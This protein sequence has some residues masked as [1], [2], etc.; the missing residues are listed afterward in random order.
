MFTFLLFIIHLLLIINAQDVTT[1]FRASSDRLKDKIN[2]EIKKLDDLHHQTEGDIQDIVKNMNEFTQ[3]EHDLLKPINDIFSCFS[4][5]GEEQI[6]IAMQL[7]RDAQHT[8]SLTEQVMEALYGDTKAQELKEDRILLHDIVEI[9]AIDLLKYTLNDLN[10]NLL[11]LLDNEQ[12]PDYSR[13]KQ[14][15]QELKTNM[16]ILKQDFD[17]LREQRPTN[18][19]YPIKADDIL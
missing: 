15:I 17:S 19:I 16:E 7:D 1:T 3:Q 13:D 2:E 9:N 14:T 18:D 4:C 10:Y 12:N 6:L 5:T 11:Q 8:L